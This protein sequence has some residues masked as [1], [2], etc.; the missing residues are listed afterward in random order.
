MRKNLLRKVYDNGPLKALAIIFL[1][2]ATALTSGCA[3]VLVVK[4]P[5][6]GAQGQATQGPSGDKTDGAGLVEVKATVAFKAPVKKTDGFPDEA[7]ARLLK[8]QLVRAFRAAG[9]EEGQGPGL[10]VLVTIEELVYATGPLSDDNP[11]RLSVVID[12][13]DLKG[14]VLAIFLVETRHAAHPLPPGAQLTVVPLGF[15]GRNWQSI[16]AMIPAAAVNITR[17]VKGIKERNGKFY[18]ADINGTET[19]ANAI[20][21]PGLYGLRPLTNLDVRQALEIEANP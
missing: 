12:V 15:S 2:A 5:D 18:N 21:S 3:G 10:K 4:E 19:N 6:P 20:L 17:V 8:A 1:L 13:M 16:S 7:Y 11:S 9:L 14:A